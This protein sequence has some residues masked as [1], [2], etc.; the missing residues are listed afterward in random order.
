M[1]PAVKTSTHS[2]KKYKNLVSRELLQE[3]KHLSKKLNGLKVVYINAT[4]RGGGVAE[5]LKSFV[6]LMKG[7]GIRAEWY[8][9][10][11]RNS[12]LSITKKMHYALQ[13][14]AYNFP[15]KD[16]KIFL[17]H[18]AKIADLMQDMKADIWV[19]HDPQPA[20]VVAFLP[21]FHPAICRL[22]MDLTQPDHEVWKFLTGFL[23]DF[24]KVIV[25]SKDFIKKEIKN[26]TV[27]FRPAIDPFALK[28]Q[29]LS[30]VQ[31][32]KIIKSF[33]INS[34]RPLIS[35]IARFD[36]LKDP[37]GVVDAYKIAKK[38]I[39]GLQLALLGFFLAV[40]DPEAIKIYQR[41]KKYVGNDPDVFL[42]GNPE[43]LGSLKV[44]VFV[45]A[46]QTASDVILQKSIREG[47]GLTVA[48]AMWK[49]KPVIGGNAGGIKAQIENGKNGFLVS[50]S[51][52][53]A[54]RIIQLIKN[55]ELSKKM[56]ISAKETVREKFLMPRL[57]RDHLKLYKE[58][59]NV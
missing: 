40:D 45:R 51:R 59:L 39:P 55:P 24:D 46:I 19:I 28:N 1:L 12:F 22:H 27:I 26:K 3:I 25:T 23:E 58:I 35:Q 13:G 50:D 44:D 52:K 57:L 10:P 9:V 21:K 18:T 36:P 20:G 29:P 47:F 5:I 48:E 16:R 2:L 34:D 14:E 43:L 37:M 41:V 6:P 53:T 42:F 38:K 8:V 15:F 32:K 31:A 56:G 30:V 49:E 7:I 11:P 17:Q 4:P 33:D 54:A